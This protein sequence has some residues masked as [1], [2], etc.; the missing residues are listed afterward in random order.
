MK[1]GESEN[2]TVILGILAYVLM[3]AFF[4]IAL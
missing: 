1:K 4:G 2:G 3:V